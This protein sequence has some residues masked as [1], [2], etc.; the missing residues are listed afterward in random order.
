MIGV[1]AV[2]RSISGGGAAAWTRL[3]FYGFIVGTTVFT[4]SMA[5][6]LAAV[7]AATASG[8]TEP[9][10]LANTV[11]VG[12]DVLQHPISLMSYIVL[13]MALA[14]LGLGMILSAVYPKWMGWMMLILG[15]LIVGVT[16]ARIVG[17]HIG[18]LSLTSAVLAGL[19]TIWAIIVGI[20]VT[21]RA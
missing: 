5:V 7:G 18:A 19:T 1:A 8:G 12:F 3:G 13:W 6:G 14:F 11:A 20:W 4:V 15:V 16:I 10:T 21:R 17:D 9:G 2:Y